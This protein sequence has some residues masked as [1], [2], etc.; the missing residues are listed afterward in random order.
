MSWG[1]HPQLPCPAQAPSA[2]LFP[3]N[4][5][6]GSSP[7]LPAPDCPDKSPSISHQE[8]LEPPGGSCYWLCPA[9]LGPRVLA[10]ERRG[11]A[12]ARG[13]S[14]ATAKPRP[15]TP[16]NFPEEGA[17]GARQGQLN[18]SHGTTTSSVWLP[19]GEG[20]MSGGLQMWQASGGAILGRVLFWRI[21]RTVGSVLG[22]VPSQR[23]APRR[24]VGNPEVWVLKP[25]G[26]GETAQAA[27]GSPGAW[28]D[29]RAQRSLL[30]SLATG[31]MGRA[32][33]KLCLQV[34]GSPRIW[35]RSER[36]CRPGRSAWRRNWTAWW[37]SG[38]STL[39]TRSM[40]AP[41]PSGAGGGVVFAR[42]EPPSHSQLT[43]IC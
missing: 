27:L 15:Q 10:R 17:G 22:P 43:Q 8:A 38:R 21:P 24:G 30:R 7:T 13:R 40:G 34:P 37:L 11:G 3:N 32:V 9:L 20:R 6:Q 42:P 35:K 31:K 41:C 18:D 23:T 1:H 36:L 12:G 2:G 16:R 5:V 14:R 4:S 26:P 33:G 25:G 39:A 19:G 29:L 28:G